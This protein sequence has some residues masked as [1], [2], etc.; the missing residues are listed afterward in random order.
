LVTRR[1]YAAAQRSPFL[2]RAAERTGRHAHGGAED[3]WRRSVKE[4]T[5]AEREVTRMNIPT[6]VR[7]TRSVTGMLLPPPF[8]CQTRQQAEARYVLGAFPVRDE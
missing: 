6:P 3:W 7:R 2:Q 5:E 4:G 1:S 8:V